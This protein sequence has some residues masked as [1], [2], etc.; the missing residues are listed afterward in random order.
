M[1]GH[2]G[3]AAFVIVLAILLATGANRFIRIILFLALFMSAI[4]YLQAKNHFCVGYAGSG[5]ENATVGSNKASKITNK[6]ALSADKQKSRQM[7]IQA[8]LIALIVTILA[9]IV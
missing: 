5:L 7:Y 3:L 9:V 2:L 4:G 6:S 8:G 1:A